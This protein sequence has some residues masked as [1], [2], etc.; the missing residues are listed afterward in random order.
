MPLQDPHQRGQQGDG[1]IEHNRPVQRGAEEWG[2]IFM[3]C[4]LGQPHEPE[5]DKKDIIETERQATACG[6]SFAGQTT[7]HDLGAEQHG[8]DENVQAEWGGKKRRDQQ[9]TG[10]HEADQERRTA[11]GYGQAKADSQ[12]HKQQALHRP[13]AQIGHADFMQ[14]AR[15]L[16][17]RRIAVVFGRHLGAD[18]GQDHTDQIGPGMCQ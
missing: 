10:G 9:R 18:V 5:H 2:P 12:G 8:K 13:D 15:L 16:V 11:R 3:D 14:A 7:D 6:R 1:G 17:L 4:Q